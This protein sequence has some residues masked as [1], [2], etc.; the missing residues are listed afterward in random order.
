MLTETRFAIHDLPPYTLGRLSEAVLRARR[1]G[2]DVIDLSQVNPDIGAPQCA[3]D[4]LV[5]AARACPLKRRRS[6]RI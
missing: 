1:D 4:H 3:V 2:C 5:Q 6:T